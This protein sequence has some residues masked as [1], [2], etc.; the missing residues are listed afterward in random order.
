MKLVVQ[1]FGRCGGFRNFF[2]AVNVRFADRGFRFCNPKIP[3]VP[4]LIVKSEYIA[5]H[6]DVEA[7]LRQISEKKIKA[8]T[9]WLCH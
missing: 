6:I 7:N 2:K 3:P 1:R 9:V 4:T 5:R 8:G